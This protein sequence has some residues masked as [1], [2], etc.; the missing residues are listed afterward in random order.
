MPERVVDAIQCHAKQSLAAV[1]TSAC[2]LLRDE[3]VVEVAV[4]TSLPV[5]FTAILK[6]E[7]RYVPLPYD[8]YV[9]TK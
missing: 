4:K 7:A 6:N 5:C 9:S 3:V 8:T 2:N 1:L